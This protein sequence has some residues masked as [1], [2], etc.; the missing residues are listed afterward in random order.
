MPLGDDNALVSALD[1]WLAPDRQRPTPTPE[2]GADA[3]IR[4]LDLFDAVAA[5]RRR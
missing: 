2:P 3:A 4:Y 1:H 5:Q